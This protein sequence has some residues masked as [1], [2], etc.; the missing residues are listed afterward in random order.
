MTNRANDSQQAQDADTSARAA[1]IMNQLHLPSLYISGFRGIDELNLPKLAQVTLFVGDN[2]VGKSTILD[3]VRLYAAR[4]NINAIA[5]L[6]DSR[7]EFSEA[8][9]DGKL[10]NNLSWPA[11]FHR[12]TFEEDQR[13]EIGPASE[14]HGGRGLVIE[15][16]TLDEDSEEVKRRRREAGGGTS[17]TF[18]KVV[19][20]FDGEEWRLYHDDLQKA[21][22]SSSSSAEIEMAAAME[23]REQADE[24]ECVS[25]SS[26]LSNNDDLGQMWDEIALTSFEDMVVQILRSVVGPDLERIGVVG[27]PLGPLYRPERRV[28]ARL[29]DDSERM[30]L[31]SLGDGAMRIFEMA[32][33]LANSTD[34]YLLIDEVE[35]GIHYSHLEDLWRMVFEAAKEH[36]IQV[37]ATTHSFDCVAGFA[38]VAN[39]IPGDNGMLIRL[40]RD[41]DGELGAATYTEDLLQISEE[42]GIEV[43]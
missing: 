13:L 25:V 24:T 23:R 14:S 39:S 37:I 41:E 19:V 21:K 18:F 15:T 12:S 33:A 43:R 28:I 2:G 32:V 10:V 35:N 4:G 40:D 1:S 22:P 20:R 26:G 17:G 29:S 34:G 3:A 9:E 16:V 6:L 38:R 31:K 42:M 5:R 36:N 8:W 27:R 30:P 11:L 7:E